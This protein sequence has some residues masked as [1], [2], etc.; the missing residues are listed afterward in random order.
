[1]KRHRRQ[2]KA[3]L[4]HRRQHMLPGVLL[5]VIETPR[6]VDATFHARIACPAVHDMNEFIASVAHGHD[7]R[8]F[9]LDYILQL[10]D[11]HRIQRRSTESQATD[12][13]AHSY[14]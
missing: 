3:F 6:P 11:R 14:A 4:K 1:M 13:Y 2:S 10:T 8:L 7:M 9:D 12:I 5:H